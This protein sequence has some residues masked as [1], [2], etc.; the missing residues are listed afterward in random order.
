MNPRKVKE[1][2]AVCK[3]TLIMSVVQE[4]DGNPDLVWVECPKCHE[5]KPLNLLPRSGSGKKGYAKAAALDQDSSENP[6][7]P[8]RIYPGGDA[9]ELGDRVYHSAW[10]DT[11]EVIEKKFSKGGWPMIVVEFKKNGKK[12]LIL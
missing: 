1:Y 12:K 7:S 8:M 11:G 9:Y 10:D 5:V 3:K 6:E 2:C 4:E